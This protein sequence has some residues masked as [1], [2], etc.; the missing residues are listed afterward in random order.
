MSICFHV[1]LYYRLCVHRQC[2][3]NISE[4]C[5]SCFYNINVFYWPQNNPG[6]FNL[7]LHVCFPVFFCFFL[8]FKKTSELYC[9]NLWSL[10]MSAA[11]IIA[12]WLSVTDSWFIFSFSQKSYSDIFWLWVSWRG[13]SEADELFYPKLSFSFLWVT[14]HRNMV[15]EATRQ[16]ALPYSLLV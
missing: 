11:F 4:V 6:F 12:P 10:N 16:W 5:G 3:I 8:W 1:T 15:T 14:G 9:L 7:F 2:S 13:R